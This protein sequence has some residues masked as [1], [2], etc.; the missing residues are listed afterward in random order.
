MAEP[1]EKDE[2]GLTNLRKLWAAQEKKVNK[3]KQELE[4]ASSDKQAQ[5]AKKDREIAALEKKLT[6]SGESIENLKGKLDA[7]H[8]KYLENT[9]VL[10]NKNKEVRE[11]KEQIALLEGELKAERDAVVRKNAEFEQYKTEVEQSE[12]EF[13]KLKSDYDE[14]LDHLSELRV[15]FAK[16][17]EE[18]SSI[19]GLNA[20]LNSKLRQ[21]GFD[22]QAISAKLEQT[23]RKLDAE[24]QGIAKTLAE[25][26][27]SGWPQDMYSLRRDLVDI[28]MPDGTEKSVV[29]AQRLCG[30]FGR[31]QMKPLEEIRTFIDGVVVAKAG[32]LVKKYTVTVN[33]P[34]T[35]VDVG[36]LSVLKDVLSS[37]I[38][39]SLEYALPD[40]PKDGVAMTFD[41]RDDGSNLFCT[42]ADNGAMFLYEKIRSLV[43]NAGWVSTGR[44][45]D[46]EDLLDYLFPPVVSN[47]NAQGGLIR[48]A[49]ALERCRGRIGAR[50]DN[51]FVLD[52]VLPKK[53]IFDKQ[54]IY[55]AGDMR[56]A[57]PLSSV[58]E[59]FFISADE[60]RS[61]VIARNGKNI[62]VLSVA[63]LPD[64]PAVLGLLIRSGP[65]SFLMPV[66][67]IDDAE[68]FLS[69]L[70]DNDG[71]P[72]FRSCL[73]VE[74]GR[75][76]RWTD[77]ASFLKE[78]APPLAV[79]TGEPAEPDVVLAPDET[80]EPYLIFNSEPH[81]YGAVPVSRVLKVESMHYGR[82][83]DDKGRA[84]FLS[85]GRVLPLRD[86]SGKQNFPYAEVVL[87]FADFA[88]AVQNVA[89]FKDDEKGLKSLD[90]RG[91]KVIVAD[92]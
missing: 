73:T 85:D 62:P 83:M 27:A 46:K 15:S 19:E 78:T 47:G 13:S 69:F 66:D 91:R 22:Y 92:F 71:S 25:L 60:V 38:E 39:N 48:A 42:F 28:L 64:A 12:N 72:Y 81:R 44:G 18:K 75:P 7:Y 10:E 52:F 86:S 88:L 57:L 21:T 29:A 89:D 3:L 53:Y 77:L 36:V 43:R 5:L 80:K 8:R 11:L 82:T 74:S 16:A 1:A 58:E 67:R 6:H 41:V 2:K 4:K 54:L 24:K 55:W 33:V 59:A 84:V 14:V 34:D 90:Y 68:T 56:C 63:P 37:A 32:E 87:I 70:P 31:M 35:P 17:T 9:T 65:F 26:R 49:E 40:N 23:E 76:C 20:E 61:G 50:F 79:R 51:G 30:T 45:L